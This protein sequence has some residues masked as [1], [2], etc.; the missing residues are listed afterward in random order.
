MTIGEMI[1]LLDFF[2][3]D[4][5]VFC[6]GSPFNTALLNRQVEYVDGEVKVIEEFVE[7]S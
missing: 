3:H 5:E 4:L 7:L 1:K 6:E 2:D